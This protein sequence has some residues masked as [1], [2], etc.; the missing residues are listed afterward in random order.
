M[1]ETSNLWMLMEIAF[2]EIWNGANPNTTLKEMSE[3]IMKQV[4]GRHYEEMLLPEPE[5]VQITNSHNAD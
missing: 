2:T 5:A 4:V 3:S 1:I